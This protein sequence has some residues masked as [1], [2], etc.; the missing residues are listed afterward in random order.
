[1][2]NFENMG[3]LWRNNIEVYYTKVI[4]KR[5]FKITQGDI[6]TV[7][8]KDIHAILHCLVL[9]RGVYGFEKDRCWF[10]LAWLISFTLY[11]P[12]VYRWTWDRYCEIWKGKDT[13]Q[14]RIEI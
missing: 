4:R 1:M 13:E 2:K 10:V 9:R 5:W 8:E 11:R 6:V 3:M 7:K 14:C 12:F